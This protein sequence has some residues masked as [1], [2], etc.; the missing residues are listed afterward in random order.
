MISITKEGV[1]IKKYLIKN[2][3]VSKKMGA[4]GRNFTE[5]KFSIE[6]MVSKFGAIYGIDFVIKKYD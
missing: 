5:Y 4:E 1:F 3:K 6:R 2:P